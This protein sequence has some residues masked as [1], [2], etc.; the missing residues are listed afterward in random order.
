MVKNSLTNQKA[1][2]KLG[3][4][5]YLSNDAVKNQI[6]S[7]VGGKNGPRFISSIVSAVNANSQLQQC[8]NQSILSGALLGE[9]LNLSPSPQLGQYYLVPFNDREKG[10]VAQ[11]QLGYKGYIQLAIRS[12][13]YKKLNVLAIKEGELIRFDP[14]NEEIEVKLIEDEEERE[15]AETVGYYAMFEYTNG[16]KKAIY[17][18]KKKMEAHAMKYSMGYR[19]KKGYTF[20]E[21]DFDGMAYKTMLRQLISKWGIMSIDMQTAID[22]DMAVINADGTKNYVD[23][24]DENIIEQPAQTQPT[25]DIPG[26]MNVTDYPEMAPTQDAKAALFS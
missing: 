8:T 24:E 11:F 10:K 13:Q 25:D 6:N 1:N 7:I 20:W 12:G 4:T 2:Q 23:N 17:W 3:I 9:S 21:K 14:L 5:T 16:F 18:S 15:Q 22:A 19:A 26:Q